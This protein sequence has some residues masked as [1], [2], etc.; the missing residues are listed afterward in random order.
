MLFPVDPR[1]SSEPAARVAAEFAVTFGIDIVVLLALVP[2]E[3][4]GRGE[5]EEQVDAEEHFGQLAKIFE[6][7][8]IVTVQRVQAGDSIPEILGASRE[9]QADLLAM[10]YRRRTSDE[11]GRRLAGILK[12]SHLPVLAVPIGKP[13]EA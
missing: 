2:R 3:R 4:T 7:K 8:G 13:A 9:H 6:R 12:E 11:S 1:D 5:A 10:G